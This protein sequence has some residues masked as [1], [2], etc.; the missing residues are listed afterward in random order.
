MGRCVLDVVVVYV[1][2]NHLMDDHVLQFFLVHLIPL[3][4]I[5]GKVRVCCFPGF[6]FFHLVSQLSEIALGMAYPDSRQGQ[7]AVEAETVVFVED[8][9]YVRDSDQHEISY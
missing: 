5:Q 1:V 4:E 9:L 8:T 3:G 2:V 6:V 7:F